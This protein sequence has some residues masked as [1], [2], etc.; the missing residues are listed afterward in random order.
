MKRHP[1]VEEDLRQICEAPEVPW[2]DLAGST[3]LVTGG[4]GLIAAYVVESLLCW[5]EQN[6]AAPICVIALV[7]DEAKARR[8]FA[9]YE[10]RGDLR[11]LVQDVCLPPPPELRVDFIVHA[12]SPA[13]PKQFSVNPVGTLGP[14]VLGTHHMLELA[15]RSAA[16][17]LLYLSSGEVYGRVPIELGRPLTEDD[18]GPLDPLDVRA[19]YGESKRAGE[20]MCKAW[21]TQFGVPARIA[22]LGHTYGPGMDLRDGRVFADFVGRMVHNENLVLLSDGSAARPFCYLSDAVRGILLVLL[23]GRSG[24]AFNV[25]NDQALIR[26]RDLAGLL[27]SLFPDKHLS[28]VSSGVVPSSESFVSTS[29]GNDVDTTRIRELGWRP[30]VSIADGFRRTIL[31]FS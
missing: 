17:G 2:A 11:F 5:N 15:R 30:L 16:R 28:V 13:S 8:R 3:V 9:T 19:C 12:A 25:V 6:P 29:A 1:I 10:G 14:N 4:A 24:V 20:T 7:R 23:R 31:S 22:R 27:V 26:I 21:Q 18:Y